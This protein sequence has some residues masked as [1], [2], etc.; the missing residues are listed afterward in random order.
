MD[1]AAVVVVV[2]DSVDAVIDSVDAA[3]VVVVVVDSVDAV[4]DS[5][6]AAVVV[7]VVDSVDA[8]IDPV[9]AVVVVVGVVG[10]VVGG[11]GVVKLAWAAWIGEIIELVWFN[12]DKGMV[13]AVPRNAVPPC[14]TDGGFIV[15]NVGLKALG[16]GL[17]S[18]HLSA[19]VIIGLND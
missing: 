4:I 7:V 8:V 2:V 3:A 6:D 16:A 1:A 10:V 13:G 17:G 12:N 9:N 18:R 15:D 11:I 14:T 19:N 5:V